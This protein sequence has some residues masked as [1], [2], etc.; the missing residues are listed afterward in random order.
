MWSVPVDVLDQIIAA[1][2]AAES[3]AITPDIPTIAL[4]HLLRNAQA[5]EAST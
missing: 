2:A 5:L 1:T 4:C 3:S